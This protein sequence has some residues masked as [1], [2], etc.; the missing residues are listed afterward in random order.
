MKVT[1]E[2]LLHIQCRE[3]ELAQTNQFPLFL[4]GAYQFCVIE[5]LNINFVTQPRRDR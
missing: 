4:R 1:I 2:K 3:I 5:L